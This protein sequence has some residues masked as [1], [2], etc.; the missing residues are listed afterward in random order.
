MDKETK[1]T[2]SNEEEKVPSATRE[3]MDRPL[4]KVFNIHNCV[5][6]KQHP[7]RKQNDQIETNE[8]MMHPRIPQLQQ[9]Q[10]RPNAKNQTGLN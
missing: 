10:H 6:K 4:Q 2:R 5:Y 9:Q 3:P 1:K 8:W 7:N